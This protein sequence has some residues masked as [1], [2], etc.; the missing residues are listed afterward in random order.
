MQNSDR[1][2]DKQRWD[3]HPAQRIKMLDS[4][5]QEHSIIGL[6]RGEILDLL[7][8]NKPLISNEDMIEYFISPGYADVVGF[9]IFFDEN[10]IAYQY[11]KSMH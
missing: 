1:P 10:G 6:D 7:G 9:I 3:A 8:K 4:L 5:I 11:K 2:F